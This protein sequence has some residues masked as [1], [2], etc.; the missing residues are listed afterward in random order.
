MPWLAVLV[1]ACGGS[2][3]SSTTANV[4]IDPLPGFTGS[5]EVLVHSPAGAL[6]SRATIT[7][8]LDVAIDDGDTVTIAVRANGRTTLVSALD[9]QRGDSIALPVDSEGSDEFTT[10]AVTVPQVSGVTQWNVGTPNS[11]SSTSDPTMV[12]IDVLTGTTTTPIIG[13]ALGSAGALAMFAESSAAITGGEAPGVTLQDAVDFRAV[14]VLAT[15]PPA[16]VAADSVFT[17]GAVDLGA[18]SLVLAQVGSDVIA[19]TSFGDRLE[20][21]AFAFGSA[22]LVEAA[23]AVEGAPT[24]SVS[25]DLSVPDL[26]QLAQPAIAAT[27]PSWTLTG[28]GDYT[29]L[30]IELSSSTAPDDDYVWGF[31]APPGTT[32]I[33]LPQLPADLAAPSSLDILH[34]AATAMSGVDYA[35]SLHA[36][37]QLTTGETYETHAISLDP[38]QSSARAKH[39][40]FCRTPVTFHDC[41]QYG[42]PF[43]L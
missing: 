36:S 11:D 15:N 20:L 5:A 40:G 28:G 37:Q 35:D 21:V 3:S 1:A 29:G 6:V 33:A 12:T 7:S 38:P 32:S 13:T 43:T 39:H 26:P 25:I 14:P 27:G 4:Q 34:V 42:L 23:T 17:A 19:P 18:G 2:S 8:S 9:V 30:T 31:S 41:V 10:L 24:S 16:D 22:D